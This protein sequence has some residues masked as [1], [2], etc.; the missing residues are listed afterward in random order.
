[1]ETKV[2]PY[3][4]A[5]REFLPDL[6]SPETLEEFLRL[7]L[8]DEAVRSRILQQDQ[9]I[10]EKGYIGRLRELKDH[11]DDYGP[12]LNCGPFTVQERELREY[13]AQDDPAG[14]RVFF[15]HLAVARVELFCRFPCGNG[16]LR[17]IDMPGLGEQRL[18]N[19]DLIETLANEADLVIFLTLP[20]CTRS[21]WFDAA[22]SLYNQSQQALAGKLPIEKWSFWVFNHHKGMGNLDQCGY[23]ETTRLA[24]NVNVAATAIVD[25][26]DSREVREKVID[27]ALR[28]LA[29]HLPDNDREY[30]AGVERD[31][32]TVRDEILAF[33]ESSQNAL[34]QSP[35]TIS[36]DYRKFLK[37]FSDLWGN[38]KPRL[39]AVISTISSK[40]AQVTPQRYSSLQK[41]VEKACDV[42][43]RDS[44]LEIQRASGVAILQAGGWGSAMDGYFSFFRRSAVQKFGEVWEKHAYNDLDQVKDQFCAVL[45]ENGRFNELFQ[46]ADRH[47]LKEILVFF[48]EN[49]LTEDCHE[50]YQA[51]R[52]LEEKEKEL[53]PP[54]QEEKITNALTSLR[55]LTRGDGLLIYP[56]AATF[57]EVASQTR[58]ACLES[59]RRSLDEMDFQNNKRVV[60]CVVDCVRALIPPLEEEDSCSSSSKHGIGL[61]LKDQWQAFFFEARKKI[62]PGEFSDSD[63][64]AFDNMRHE[65]DKLRQ[66]CKW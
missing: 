20:S 6:R 26:T 13:M 51:L 52:K 35:K 63:E 22:I 17:F 66:A 10:L 34:R 2:L 15:K 60:Q 9:I 11:L 41:D 44:E 28:Y 65:L 43:A 8:P 40:Q 50:M 30:S 46:H 33:V 39:Y 16:A 54:E 45:A 37:L 57:N 53:L 24:A 49:L 64:E 31:A 12:L 21:G 55:P 61:K 14:K 38:L 59:L 4:A 47:L 3:Y 1:M 27:P 18:G 56:D 48:E 23:L 32:E 25:C 62:W 36:A 5:L 29:D 42:L 58:D 19:P 7:P